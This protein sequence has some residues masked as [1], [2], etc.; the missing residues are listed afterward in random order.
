MRIIKI[1]CNPEFSQDLKDFIKKH[2]RTSMKS[3]NNLSAQY[4]IE[5]IEDEIDD[6]DFDVSKEDRELLLKIEEEKINYIEI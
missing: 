5:F 1:A 3:N 4:F 2:V 6:M